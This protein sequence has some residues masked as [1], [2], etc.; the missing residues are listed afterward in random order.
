M[1]TE[2]YTF[3]HLINITVCE[4]MEIC[5][6]CYVEYCAVKSLSGALPPPPPSPLA[7]LFFVQY[8]YHQPQKICS[9]S[10]YFGYIEY[11]YIHKIFFMSYYTPNKLFFSFL[12]YNQKNI[13]YQAIIYCKFTPENEY[14]YLIIHN[15]CL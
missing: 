14:G 2:I 8:D 12:L 4:H 11:V 7:I 3:F 10:A 9:C 1:I 13:I 15:S 5:K 6:S